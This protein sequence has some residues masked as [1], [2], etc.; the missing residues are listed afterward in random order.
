MSEMNN[1]TPETID[2]FKQQH[3]LNIG[4]Q[5]RDKVFLSKF[6]LFGCGSD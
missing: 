4:H 2:L 1:N 3:Q 6:S 5:Q